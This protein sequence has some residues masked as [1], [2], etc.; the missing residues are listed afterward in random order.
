MRPENLTERLRC[1]TCT[2]LVGFH[3]PA[4]EGICCPVHDHDGLEVVY[5]AAG[6]GVTRLAA[7]SSISFEQGG[8]VIYPPRTLHDQVMNR[9]GMDV[10]V[11]MALSGSLPRALESPLYVRRV[12][13]PWLVRELDAL[14]TGHPAASPAMRVALAHRSAAVL[15]RLV[16]A[17]EPHPLDD[18]SPAEQHAARAR[19]YIDEHF[20]GIER[21]EQVAAAIGLGPDYL[22]HAFQRTYGVS[23]IGYLIRIRMARAQELLLHSALPHKAIADLCGIDDDKYFARVF[24]KN[25]G[26][27]PGAF[28]KRHRARRMG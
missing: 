25:V 7:G 13:D 15:V 10:C 18:T 20:Q 11:Q 26:T 23:P 22:R 3:R 9:P 6:D 27:T 4:C 16:E 24:R 8:A 17:A 19:Q 1:S 14:G 5:H 28:R 21:I 12:E 2:Y